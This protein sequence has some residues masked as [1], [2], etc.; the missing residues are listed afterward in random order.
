MYKIK[1]KTPSSIKEKIKAVKKEKINSLFLSNCLNHVSTF[2]GT[3]AQNELNNIRHVQVPFSLIV[4]VDYT[5]QPGSHW[6]SIYVSKHDIEIFDSLGFDPR[7]YSHCTNIIINFISKYSFNRNLL[8]SP[9][10]QS[11]SSTLCGLYCIY[12]ILMRQFY[13]FNHCLS[14]FGSNR[15]RNDQRLVHFFNQL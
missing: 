1:T 7:F 8:I 9:I 12:F 6:L 4:N 3:F 2:L 5:G 10:L 15:N 14:R 11:P 13:S